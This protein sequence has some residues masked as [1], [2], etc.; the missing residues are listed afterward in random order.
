[1]KCYR[2]SVLGAFYDYE[3]VTYDDIT[4][5]E[6]KK[7]FKTAYDTP[8]GIIRVTEV[9]LSDIDPLWAMQLE[10]NDGVITWI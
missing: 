6:L 4:A 1:M 3:F 10:Q 7:W 2:V 8:C 5:K 9:N